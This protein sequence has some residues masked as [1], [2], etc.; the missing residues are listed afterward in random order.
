N[1]AQVIEYAF[2]GTS[3]GLGQTSTEIGY[4][5]PFTLNAFNEGYSDAGDTTADIYLIPDFGTIPTPSQVTSGTYIG[6]YDFGYLGTYTYTV[7]TPNIT[8]PTYVSPGTYYVGYALHA[9]NGQYGT[10]INTVVIGDQTMTGYCNSD[11]YEPDGS[12]AQASHLISG[13]V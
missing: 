9:A 6:T 12:P 7:Q 5:F 10:D 3:K 2:N 1:L 13:V 8:I 4:S 11:A